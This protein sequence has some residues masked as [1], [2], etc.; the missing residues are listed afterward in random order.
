MSL[1]QLSACLWESRL[2]TVLQKHREPSVTDACC[3][4]WLYR[5]QVDE[6]SSRYCRQQETGEQCG[7]MEGVHG[8]GQLTIHRLGK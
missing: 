1:M 7:A 2:D 6:R 3:W 8:S 4:C 5:V